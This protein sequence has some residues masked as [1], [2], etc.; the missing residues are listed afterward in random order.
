MVLLGAGAL[1]SPAEN[2]VDVHPT[3]QLEAPLLYHHE[4]LLSL[5]NTG[6]SFTCG[7]PPYLCRLWHLFAK[8]C[9]GLD[10]TIP[11]FPCVVWASWLHSVSVFLSVKWGWG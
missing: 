6:L 1:V 3:E 2:Q 9:L 7:A 4:S 11:R 5:L 8:S 10:I